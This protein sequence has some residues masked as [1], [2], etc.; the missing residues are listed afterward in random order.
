MNPRIRPWTSE[1][2]SAALAMRRDGMRPPAIGE[3]LQRAG[4]AVSSRL[5]YLALTP[6][7]RLQK[8]R[9]KRDSRP[10]RAQAVAR[11]RVMPSNNKLVPAAVLEERERR[12]LEPRSL[13]A[14]LMG[15]PPLSRSAL[16]RRA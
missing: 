2:D 5:R 13:S 14:I 15:D 8:N 7:E 6:A 1:E 9:A 4:G 3:V 11:M 16:G 12:L 10:S